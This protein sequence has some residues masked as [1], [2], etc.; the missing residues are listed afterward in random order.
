MTKIIKM[1]QVSK[2][3]NGHEIISDLNMNVNQG[4]IYGFLGPNGAGKT[5]TMRMIANLIQPT[6]GKIE[7]F[8]QL[9]TPTSYD[10]RKRI[11]SLIEYPILYENLTALANLEIHC[12]YMGFHDKKAIR[13]ALE[14]TGLTDTKGKLVK[15]FSIGMKQ[16]L[17]LA[18]A[19]CTKPEL[20]ILDEPVN[21]LDPIGIQEQ[22]ELFRMLN[23]EYGIT[24]FISSHI[25]QEIE[26]LAD[27]IGVI[28]NG[29]LIKE[30][31]MT[32]VR[33]QPSDYMEVVVT[34][35]KKAA[36]VLENKMMITNFKVMDERTI[37]IYQSDVTPVDVSRTL[38]ENDIGLEAL[39]KKELSLEE[40]FLETIH[41]GDTHA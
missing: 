37:R 31:S 28:Q 27:T 34:N 6:S 19:I 25:L 1:K 10:I 20:L 4:E 17:G 22:R 3:S 11:G 9:L 40:F 13:D 18:R 36:F 5:T 14:L 39:I 26:Y 29:K 32:Q 33:S 24:L 7:L 15:H 23:R 41:R 38:I 21:G 30:V 16:R 35:S 8:G 2:V 12:E